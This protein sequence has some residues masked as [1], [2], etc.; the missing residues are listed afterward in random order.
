MKKTKALSND[1][2]D[3]ILKNIRSEKPENIK[4]LVA[5]IEQKF[6]LPEKKIIQIM[7]ELENKKL[8]FF[9][10]DLSFHSYAKI[11]RDKLFKKNFFLKNGWYLASLI[12]LLL[13]VFVVFIVPENLYPA[14]YLRQFL[15]IIFIMFLPGFA[16]I[17]FL[18]PSKVRIKNSSQYMDKLEHLVLSI[19]ASL[20]LTSLVGLLLNYAPWGI[21]LIPVTLSL[22]ALTLVLATIALL[23]QNRIKKANELE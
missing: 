7:L 17:K 20:I 13:T 16:L 12:I 15:G 22:S 8:L 1:I 6:S 2:S 5:T 11:H 4:N 18:Y 10:K 23:N 21:S 3:Y 14:M 9:S 19:G